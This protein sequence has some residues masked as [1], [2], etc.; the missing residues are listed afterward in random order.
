M[1]VENVCL[2]SARLMPRL[3]LFLEMCVL[4]HVY[5]KVLSDHS[6]SQSHE[7]TNA[8]TVHATHMTS[9]RHISSACQTHDS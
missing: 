3:F 2:Y 9:D 6:S 4:D 7:Q 1:Q 8:S 5:Y